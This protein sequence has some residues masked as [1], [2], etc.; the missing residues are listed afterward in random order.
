[1]VV[2]KYYLFIYLLFFSNHLFYFFRKVGWLV[3]WL[4]CLLVCL[5]VC[6][7]VC[8]FVGPLGL[9]HWIQLLEVF[10][11]L[12]KTGFTLRELVSFLW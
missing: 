10:F 12:I 7:F 3:G 8:L 1:M 5:F 4:V 9:L 2:I 11:Y 6:W